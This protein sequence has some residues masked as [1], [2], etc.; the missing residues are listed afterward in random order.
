MAKETKPAVTQK[1]TA[2]PSTSTQD[3]ILV[4]LDLG[5]NASCV[6]AA[7]PGQPDL[8]VDDTVPTLVGYAKEGLIDGILPG[9]A[10]MLFGQD[11]IK[12]RLHLEVVQP[13]EA[14]VIGNLRAATDYCRHMRD[15]L[16]LTNGTEARAVVGVPARTESG[17]REHVRQAVS[18]VFDKVILI[19]EPFLAALG[20]RDESRLTDSTYIDPVNNSLF[21][22][23]GAGS[24][25]LCLVQGYYPQPDDQI[26][27]P[28]AGDAVD[29]AL[30]KEISQKYPDCDLSMPKV[31]EI[32]EEFSYVGE[33]KGPIVVERVI[34]GKVKK[35]DVGEEI[36]RACHELLDLVFEGVREVIA[37][38][39]PD[40]VPELLQ[41]IV[42][43]GGG[44]QIK[45]FDT[46]LQKLLED[47]GFNQPKVRVAGKDY[48]QFVARGAIK[49]ARAAKERQWQTL[50]S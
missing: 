9:D 7:K 22:D 12:H 27:I 11:A 41:N 20:F 34:G 31:R 1:P 46:E 18:G 33:L 36:G 17:A 2:K 42:L 43:T 15:R 39:N 8:V 23:I 6:K 40:S 13:L 3:V 10:E 47:D 32:K 38:A 45:N 35:L 24:T 48:K 25:D 37:K 14:G 5:T 50:I 49:A 4:G 21:I 19:P 44:S 16:N 26:S 29:A 28:F 30:A